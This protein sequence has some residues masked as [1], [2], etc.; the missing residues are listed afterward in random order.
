MPELFPLRWPRLRLTL[1]EVHRRAGKAGAPAKPFSG[2]ALVLL[3]PDWA[4]EQAGAR[5]PLQELRAIQARVL[6][7][8]LV[9]DEWLDKG[10]DGSRVAPLLTEAE[11]R[12][13]RLFLEGHPFWRQWRRLLR[14]QAASA[15][16]ERSARPRRFDAGLVRALGGKA[17]LLRWPAHAVAHLAGRPGQAGRLESMFSRF[18]GVLQLFDDLA[19][20][21]EDERSG[22]INAALVADRAGTPLAGLM[23]LAAAREELA[24]LRREAR[25]S[26]AAV[27]ARLERA[28]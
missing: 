19:D 2:R 27:C 8:V 12:L 26:F 15:R 28:G 20:V 23:V 16:W 1:R 21:E 25:G 22:Q 18:L 24:S 11:R 14:A 17:A 10:G 5:V 3:F 4:A 9:R 6:A 13:A 7:A